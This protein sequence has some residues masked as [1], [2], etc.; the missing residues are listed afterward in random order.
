MQGARAGAIAEHGV[1]NSGLTSYRSGNFALLVS[2][3][4]TDN[5]PKILKRRNGNG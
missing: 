5:V 4:Q 3:Y 2:M 1:Y